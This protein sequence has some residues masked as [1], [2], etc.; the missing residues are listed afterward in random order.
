M[1]TFGWSA[2]L[3]NLDASV[4]NR[5]RH[6]CGCWPQS[7][8]LSLQWTHLVRRQ[9]VDTIFIFGVGR[10]F[11]RIPAA[12]SQRHDQT[13]HRQGFQCPRRDARGLFM[14]ALQPSF[15]RDCQY[16]VV[17]ANVV[18]EKNRRRGYAVSINVC[19][20]NTHGVSVTSSWGRLPNRSRALTRTFQRTE[21]A[22]K[23]VSK[24]LARRRRHGYAVVEKSIAF[25]VSLA[26]LPVAQRQLLLFE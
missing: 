18:P 8:F 16:Y 10:W 26:D 13:C 20:R 15:A 5:L 9:A 19:C 24:I 3:A 11:D 7:P 25:P 14:I 1:V 4:L 12:I 17:L 6:R 23:Y 2:R 21:D 22:W